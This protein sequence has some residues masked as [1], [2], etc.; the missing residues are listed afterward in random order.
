MKQKR[1]ADD[2]RQGVYSL[3]EIDV[4]FFEGLSQ[5]GVGQLA[6]GG[7]VKRA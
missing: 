1:P 5:G 6:G 4:T 7:A 3:F 2:G